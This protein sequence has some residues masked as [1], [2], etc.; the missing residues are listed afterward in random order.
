MKHFLEKMTSPDWVWA[1]RYECT[2]QKDETM[3]MQD[4][5]LFFVDNGTESMLAVS[6]ARCFMVAGSLF[7]T[8]TLTL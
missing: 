8:N 7:V 6:Y 3:L 2:E 4:S 1:E 5:I